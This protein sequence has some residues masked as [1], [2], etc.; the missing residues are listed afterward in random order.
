MDWDTEMRREWCGEGHV[1]P[2]KMRSN[3][4]YSRISIH[5]AVDANSD[6][7]QL[8]W[9]DVR[10]AQQLLD[11][12]DRGL[13]CSRWIEGRGGRIAFGQYLLNEMKNVGVKIGEHTRN[14]M[15]RQFGTYHISS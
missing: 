3:A 11:H 2:A 5:N 8:R 9:L 4:G 15:Y 12:G 7:Q 1:S 10:H 14:G 13:N 6:P